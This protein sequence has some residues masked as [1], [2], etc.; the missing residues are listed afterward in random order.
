MSKTGILIRRNFCSWASALTLAVF[1]ALPSVAA[2]ETVEVP[3]ESLY[4]NGQLFAELTFFPK[5]VGLGQTGSW[6]YIDPSKYTLPDKLIDAT[7]SSAAYWSGILGDGAKNKTPWQIFITTDEDQNAG[8]TT[9]AL[10]STGTER[11]Y[12]WS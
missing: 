5:D 12:L 10:R 4:H 7:V 8:A 3:M 6:Y 2:A 1:F 11:E 9:Y